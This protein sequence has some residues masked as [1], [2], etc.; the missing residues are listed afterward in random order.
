[1]STACAEITTQAAWDAYQFGV[2]Q[3]T[4]FFVMYTTDSVK[5]ATEVACQAACGA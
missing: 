2:C 5:H 4:G 3:D 1:L